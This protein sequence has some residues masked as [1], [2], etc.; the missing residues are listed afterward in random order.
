MSPITPDPDKSLKRLGEH[1]GRSGQR[2]RGG[3]IAVK[4]TKVGLLAAAARGQR[5]GRP[6][7]MD[8][9]EFGADKAMLASGALAAGGVARQ[10][11]VAVSMQC[12]HLSGG[13]GVLAEAA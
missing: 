1:T 8:E 11:G 9:A 13:L 2:E 3:K 7:S 12:R 5:Y 4:R 10:L 6:R